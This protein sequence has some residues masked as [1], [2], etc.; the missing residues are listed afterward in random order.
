[1]ESYYVPVFAAA[2]RPHSIEL[3]LIRRNLLM[4][5]EVRKLVWRHADQARIDELDVLT[6]G[7]SILRAEYENFRSLPIGC[8]PS[9][10]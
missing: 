7:K 4:D 3:Q 5:I 9:P 8:R 10:P 2:S 1:M 6:A